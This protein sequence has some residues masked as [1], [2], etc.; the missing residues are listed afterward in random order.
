[1]KKEITIASLTFFLASCISGPPKLSEA[2]LLEA[3]KIAIY[4]TGDEISREYEVIKSI[5]IADCSSQGG[6]WVRIWGNE[7]KAIEGLVYKAYSFQ[8]DAII[9]VACS[10]APLVNNCWAAKRCNGT[11][12]KWKNR[13][14]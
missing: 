10:A 4:K 5:E 8:A 14:A 13:N 9:D 7:G 1:M 3:K 6:G 2:E 12:I 11:A